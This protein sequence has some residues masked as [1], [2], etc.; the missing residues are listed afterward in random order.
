MDIMGKVEFMVISYDMPG[1][2]SRH[3]LSQKKRTVRA[4][5][6][7]AFDYEKKASFVKASDPCSKLNC[8][9]DLQCPAG[10]HSI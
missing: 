6:R 4:V 9:T 8:C 1:A 10:T 3:F 7:R 5:A 2:V